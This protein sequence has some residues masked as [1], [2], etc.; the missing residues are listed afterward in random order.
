MII[1]YAPKLQACYKLTCIH[2]LLAVVIPLNNW[3]PLHYNICKI[4]P[5]MKFQPGQVWRSIF[6]R[7]CA[8]N[9]T[10]N[11]FVCFRNTTCVH[12]CLSDILQMLLWLSVVP[13]RR[14]AGRDEVY[15][16]HIVYRIYTVHILERRVMLCT[17]A[18]SP[19]QCP[20]S[21]ISLLSICVDNSSQH[22]TTPAEQF[23]QPRTN[24]WVLL[25]R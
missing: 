5:H 22:W 10:V 14:V 8:Q 24:G 15:R 16:S 9:T 20:T 23:M 7:L 13:A 18:L 1:G 25:P 11:C 21:C 12:R 19:I 3:L 17:L 2:V 4:G 6:C